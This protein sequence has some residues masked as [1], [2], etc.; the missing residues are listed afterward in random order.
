VIFPA[1]G[2]QFHKFPCSFPVKQGIW[3][4][5][6]FAVDWFV[7]HSFSLFPVRS[8]CAEN[9]RVFRWLRCTIASLRQSYPSFG[10]HAGAFDRPSLSSEKGHFRKAHGSEGQRPGSYCERLVRIRSSA[11]EA[12]GYHPTLGGTR[13]SDFGICLQQGQTTR[14]RD[15][16]VAGLKQGRWM[17]ESRPIP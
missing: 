2:A 15:D 7:S 14:G 4:R 5:D 13:T 17:W 11:A 12:D 16:G 3:A 9:L 6:G 8:V 10:A 1:F